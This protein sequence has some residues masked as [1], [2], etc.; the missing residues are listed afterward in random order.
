MKAMLLRGPNMPFE[1][2]QVPDP[3]AG[4]GEAVARV[5]TCGSGL[6][7]QHAKAGRRPIPFPRII[8]HEITGEIVEVGAGVN[9]LAVGD[10]VTAYF[11]LNCGHCRW[12]LAQLEPLC[13]N[14]GGN[15]GMNCD[16]GYAEYIKLPAHI[17][18]KLPE[19]VDYKAHPAE[20][21]VVTDALATP[22]KV[23]R[24]AHIKAGE[25]VAVVGAGGG[26]GIHQVMMAKWARARV[27]AVDTR[28]QKFDA[29][30]KAGADDTVDAGKGRV[31][32]QLLE[33]TKG[34]GVD[35]VVDY[36]SSRET[37]EAGAKAL[38]RRG[39]LVTLG[40]A[41]Q[42]FQVS[43][44]DMLDKELEL[45][46]SRYVTRSE[47]LDCLDLVARGE[48]FPL[49]TEVRPLAEAEA[50]HERVERGEVIGRAA[51]RIA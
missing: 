15:V 37:L 8:G 36:V 39:R 16:G 46:G 26:L 5:I 30:R 38:R 1:P 4:P 7:I 3:V 40:G 9:G 35:V 11:Y 44:K 24:R 6:T 28:A 31:V 21:G 48:V 10:P 50:V 34:E 41:G 25:T 20:I 45:L 18:I 33:L 47:I 32:E 27:I 22:Y 19:N 29:C 2:V 23:L 13:S 51:L 42:P 43:A 12:C 14:G 49:V 17:F